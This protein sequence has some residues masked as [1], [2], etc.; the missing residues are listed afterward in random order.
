MTNQKLQGPMHLRGKDPRLTQVKTTLET[1]QLQHTTHLLQP[2]NPKL[3]QTQKSKC[4]E[5]DPVV[6][7]AKFPLGCFIHQGQIKLLLYSI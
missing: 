2:G 4:W 5:L 7:G 6:R 1:L 3:T